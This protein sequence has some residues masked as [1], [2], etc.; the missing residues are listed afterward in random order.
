MLNNQTADV[1]AWTDGKGIP[2][3]KYYTVYTSDKPGD[4][5]LWVTLHTSIDL[6]PEFY[7]ILLNRFKIFKL[8]DSKSN[9]TV[10]CICWHFSLVEIKSTT[11]S[12]DEANVKTTV[13]TISGQD[14][15]MVSISKISDGVAGS[16]EW[17][18]DRV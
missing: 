9:L 10:V 4:E 3:R 8:G 17:R 16:Q 1:I 15:T 5:E 14:I 13:Y 2:T 6:N 18:W 11:D 7:D 12:F